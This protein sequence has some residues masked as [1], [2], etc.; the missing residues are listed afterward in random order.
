LITHTSGLSHK[1]FFVHVDHQMLIA[2]EKLRPQ[3][4][5]A[6]VLEDAPG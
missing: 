4:Y 1:I 2:D 5:T 3:P 6:P